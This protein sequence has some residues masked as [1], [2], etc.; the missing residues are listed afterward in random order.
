[1][2][3]KI[4]QAQDYAEA[5]SGP[6]PSY[7]EEVARQTY[8]KTM[9]PQMLSGHLQGRLLSLLSHLVKPVAVLEIGSFTGYATLCLA[10]GLAP[11]GTV[12]TIEGNPENAF[13]AKRN[14]AASPFTD[15]IALHVGTAAEVLPTLPDTF[16]LI[17]LD[18]DKRGYPGYFYELIDRLRPG[19]L[20]IADNILWDGKVSNGG[21]QNAD[22]AALREYNE[23]VATDPRVVTVVLPLRDGLSLAR[24]V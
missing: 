15:E 7:L 16:D 9:A 4:T 11:G 1:M 6:V 13:W 17:F 3:D 8:L 24:R 18:A 21:K 14:F 2:R 5:L 22:V 10:E 19:G 23:L 12:H 20:L